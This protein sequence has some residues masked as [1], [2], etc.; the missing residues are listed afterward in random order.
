MST[1]RGMYMCIITY[2]ID[3]HN[4]TGVEVNYLPFQLGYWVYR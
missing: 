2:Q 3:E 1:I 4:Y